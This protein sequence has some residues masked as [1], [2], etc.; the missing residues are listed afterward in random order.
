MRHRAAVWVRDRTAL[1]GVLALVGLADVAGAVTSI[2]A[3]DPKPASC[4]PAEPAA[5]LVDQST[6]AIEGDPVPKYAPLVHLERQ[7][8]HFPMPAECFL[9]HSGLSWARLSARNDEQI[10]PLSEIDA[11]RLGGAGGGYEFDDQGVFRSHEFTRPFASSR[12]RLSGRRGFYLDVEDRFR[13]GAAPPAAERGVFSGTPVYYEFAPGHYVTYW[14]F[15]GFSAPAGTK[16]AVAGVVG[17][18]GDWERV[19]VRL[20]GKI[21]TDVAYYQ[22]GGEPQ[23]IP[24]AGVAKRGT[25]PVVYSGRG[26]HA[27][28]PSAGLQRKFVDHTGLGQEW[29]TWE[30]LADA[31]KQPWFRYGGAWG[32][33]RLVPKKLQVV[34]KLGPGEFTGPSGPCSKK[35]APNDWLLDATV[36]PPGPGVCAPR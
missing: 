10:E 13:F 7:E 11:D 29:R 25:H 22:H 35:P 14:F 5:V 28:Y 21:A 24:Y 1:L 17:H 8:A 18:E 26:S 12:A 6:P 19:T 32:V 2:F 16:S 3:P 30:L 9:V 4:A 23:E 20:S 36:P 33:V 31:T 34:A 27:S 15:F